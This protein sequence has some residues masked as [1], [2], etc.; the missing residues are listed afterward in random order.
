[1]LDRN[2]AWKLGRSKGFLEATSAGILHASTRL[3]PPISELLLVYLDLAQIQDGIIPF[4]KDSS[5]EGEHAVPPVANLREQ[6]LPRMKDIRSRIDEVKS[7][8]QPSLNLIDADYKFLV[9][10]SHHLLITGKA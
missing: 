4:I 2:Y 10:R 6:L 5:G 8:S 9:H 3:T 7:S 1:M